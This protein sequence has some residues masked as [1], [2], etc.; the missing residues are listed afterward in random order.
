[1]RI[2]H[3]LFWNQ[4]CFIAYSAEILWLKSKLNIIFN[5]SK[6][7]LENKFLLFLVTSNF[8]YKIFFANPFSPSFDIKGKNP[9]KIK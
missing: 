8:P 3:K 6:A 1:M 9:V 7:S 2:S 4:G 5:R